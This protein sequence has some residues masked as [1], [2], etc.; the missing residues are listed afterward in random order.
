MVFFSGLTST[1]APSAIA[2]VISRS[3]PASIGTSPKAAPCA[4]IGLTELNTIANGITPRA[5]ISWSIHALAIVFNSVNPILAQ[6][7]AFGDLPMLAGFDLD[8]TAAIADGA[9]VEVNP[10]TKT[11]T[12]LT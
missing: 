1:C 12:V 6:G 7:A 11:I 2:L 4:R 3:N 9:Q 10:E 8:I 5:C